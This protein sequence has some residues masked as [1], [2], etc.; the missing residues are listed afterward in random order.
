MYAL[1]N[2]NS[3]A[4][5]AVWDGDHALEHI[6]NAACDPTLWPSALDAMAKA[7][8]GLC[9][10]YFTWNHVTDTLGSFVG[11]SEYHGDEVY[12]AHYASLDPR[13]KLTQRLPAG[14]IFRCHEHL[15]E[16]YVRHSTFFQEFAL[17]H[18]RRFTMANYLLR[19]EELSCFAVLHRSPSQGLFSDQDAALASR[20][21]PH[22]RRATQVQERL[23]QSQ[24]ALRSSEA[25]WNLVSFAM[26]IV[27]GSG[28]VLSANRA[29]EDIIRGSDGLTVRRGHLAASDPHAASALHAFVRAAAEPLRRGT[30]R[31][32]AS[33]LVSRP[34]GRQP[35]R[36]LIAPLAEGGL[37]ETSR[38]RSAIVLI[39]D[40]EIAALPP[41]HQ[42]VSLF[43]LTA[44]EARVALSLCEGK[45]V[46][47]IA[48]ER[49]VSAGTVRSQVKAILR[50]TETERQA[51][52]VR[53]I[54]M[55]PALRP[56]T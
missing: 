17:P 13:R 23:S 26:V 29:A 54:L 9:A 28:R 42:L 50:K 3:D 38:G 4:Y 27:D 49:G 48:D 1:A 14:N 44:A 55:V 36:L 7:I 10:T 25:A 22:L 56:H 20:F 18:E 34:S 16:S 41:E 46:E 2:Q 31:V 19:T 32:G 21:A 53:S 39:T 51:D 12:R 52:L 40:P 43:G 45:R 8:G 47:D 15:D 11:S 5:P 37:H 24:A 33:L 30:D 35:Y 6:Y